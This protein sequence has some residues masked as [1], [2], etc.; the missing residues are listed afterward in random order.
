MNVDNVWVAHIVIHPLVTLPIRLVGQSKGDGFYFAATNAALSKPLSRTNIETSFL[1]L[2]PIACLSRVSRCCW[3]SFYLNRNPSMSRRNNGKISNLIASR[4]YRFV[5]SSTYYY[6]T[7]PTTHSNE[8]LLGTH[9]LPWSRVTLS[10][11]LLLDNR[12]LLSQS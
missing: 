4:G 7:T 3:I 5:P 6:T 9:T 12:H 2:P 11:T 8:F 1:L 10:G